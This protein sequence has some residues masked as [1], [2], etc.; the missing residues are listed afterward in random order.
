MTYSELDRASDQFALKL[1]AEGVSTGDVVGL[2]LPRTTRLWVAIL[3]IFKAGAAYLPLELN[4]PA[5]RL[6]MMLRCADARLV[7]VEASAG[8]AP[9]CEPVLDIDA[10]SSTASIEATL[11]YPRREDLAYVIFTSGSTGSPKGVMINHG[12]LD[13]LLYAMDLLL[14]LGPDDVQLSISPVSFDITVPDLFLPLVSGARCHMAPLERATDAD[15]LATEIAEQLVTVLQA[16]PHTWKRLLAGGWEGAPALTAIAG[17]DVLSQSLSDTLAERVGVLWHCYGPTEATVWA[18]AK[19]MEPGDAVSLGDSLAGY[20][21]SVR[22]EQGQQQVSGSAGELYIGGR[23]LADGYV[24][25]TQ[26]TAQCFLTAEYGEERWYRTGDLVQQGPEGELTF[27]GRADRQ[28]KY[29]GHR[30]EPAEI[31]NLALAIR[32]VTDAA[33]KLEEGS[34][35]SLC[36]YYRDSGDNPL[37][38]TQL[39]ACIEKTLPWYMVPSRLVSLSCWPTTSS[40]KTD[41]RA[42]ALYLAPKTTANPGKGSALVDCIISLWHRQFP[43]AELD[44]SAHFFELGGDSLAAVTL[45]TSIEQEVGVDIS[46][47]TLYAYPTIGLLTKRLEGGSNIELIGRGAPQLLNFN[48]SQADQKLYCFHA[49]G[50]SVLNY[51]KLVEYL[52]DVYAVT[53][54]QAI[55]MEGDQKPVCNMDTLAILYSRAL[56]KD[57]SSGAFFLAGGSMG[58]VIALAVARKLMAMGRTVTTVMMFDSLGPGNRQLKFRKAIRVTPTQIYRRIKFR[59]FKHW[60]SLQAR[61]SL[62]LGK[63]VPHRWRYHYIESCH[64]RLLHN[65][66]ASDACREPYSGEVF[67]FRLPQMGRGVYQLPLLGWEGVLTGRVVIDEVEGEHGQ[68]I[69]SKAF[70]A[71]LRH[72]A[73][74]LE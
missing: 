4:W 58:G 15:A 2:W 68:F 45:L 71:V 48:R 31:E 32:G 39:R 14:P 18:T 73:R 46:L 62:K 38:E 24:N 26:R 61:A 37:L 6:Q 54:V 35:P 30:V 51:Q 29:L 44:A 67:F 56:V 66:L 25:D 41:Y 27:I 3:G 11:T 22:N 50:G 20:R 5:A 63:P 42:L 70:G 53:G 21:L 1:L 23:G 40:G 7:V 19:R 60:V 34:R 72:R 17:G 49:L 16:T 9:F 13:N 8:P 59:A 47:A 74:G 69:E 33:I 57:Q 10:D 55:G 64:Y 28:I 12:A 65:Y 36:L 52:G 43:L